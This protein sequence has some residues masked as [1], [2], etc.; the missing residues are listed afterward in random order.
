M[1]YNFPDM[2]LKLVCTLPHT[3]TLLNGLS[4]AVLFLPIHYLSLLV[5]CR[6]TVALEHIP[7][8]TGQKAGYTLNL[9]PF[10]PLIPLS[11]SSC[12][13]LFLLSF[14]LSLCRSPQLPPGTVVSGPLTGAAT[15]P[16]TVCA[17]WQQG[18]AHVALP[19]SAVF[20]LVI[21]YS[22]PPDRRNAYC[23]AT[24]CPHFWTPP[25]LIIYCSQLH[26]WAT[27]P[28]SCSQATS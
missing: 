21:S 26:I 12:S 19:H 8:D 3:S 10:S 16:S 13:P 24:P 7:A 5:L 25:L 9:F 2:N 1:S 23:S 20:K 22:S 4:Y 6:V 14:L 27:L 11:F 28:S 15:L 17:R 18:V